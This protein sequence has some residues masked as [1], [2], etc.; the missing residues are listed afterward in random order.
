MIKRNT[1]LVIECA[2]VFRSATVQ[3]SQTSVFDRDRPVLRMVV[4]AFLSKSSL[5]G[6][7]RTVSELETKYPRSWILAEGLS[8]SDRACAARSELG[9]NVQTTIQTTG[10]QWSQTEV[11][12]TRTHPKQESR[13]TYFEVML[14]CSECF[15][16]PLKNNLWR[17]VKNL[18]PS[19]VYH[20]SQ[21][22]YLETKLK[23]RATFKVWTNLR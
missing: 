2:L 12:H 22:Y 7:S 3:Y 19:L 9:R 20:F 16:H 1:G 14:S 5:A 23:V 4:C 6:H 21:V 17:G 10:W 13:H 18:S 8:C 15:C 11:L